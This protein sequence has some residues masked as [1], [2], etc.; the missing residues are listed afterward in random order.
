MIMLVRRMILIA[1]LGWVAQWST[2]ALAQTN[3]AIRIVELSGTV[4]ILGHGAADW[5]PAAT[6]AQLHPFDRV[7]TGTNG[8]LGL[9]WSD[10][11]VLRFGALTEL[12]ILPADTAETDRGLHLIRGLLSFFHRD[13]PGRIRVI[14]SGALAGI[15]GTEFVMD[16]VPKNGVQQTTLSVIDGQVRFSN[17]A[18]ALILTN[19]EQA[20]AEPGKAPVRTPGFIAKN[21]LQWCFYYPGVLDPNDL[22]LTPDESTRLAESI[23]AYRAGDL[24]AA[25]AKYSGPP[26]SDAERVYHAALLLSVGHVELA[27]ADL[28]ALKETGVGKKNRRLAVALRTLIAAVKHEP[29]S[30]LL[31]PELATELLAAS[32]YEQSQDGPKALE[33]ALEL[34]RHAVAIS[35]DFGFG[36]ERVAELEFS[37]GRIDRASAALDQALRLSPRNAQALALKGFLLAAKNRTREAIAWFDRALGVDSTLGN[38]WLGRGLCRIRLG[39]SAG[40]REDLLIAAAME[41]QR[42]SLRSYLGKAYGDAGEIHRAIHELNLAKQMDTN[43]PTAWLYS[44]LLNEQKNHINEAINDLE[45]SQELNDN[46]SVYRS[47]LLLD[48]DRAV[49]SANLARIYQEAGMDLVSLQEA[50]RAVTEDYANYSAHLFLAN[51]YNSLSDPNEINLRYQTSTYDEYL[52]G[53]LL[54]P[55]SAGVFSPSISQQEYSRLFERDGFGVISETTYLSRGAWSESGAQFGTSGNFSYDLEGLYDADNGQR[56]NNDIEERQLSLTLKQQLTPQDSLFGTVINYNADGGDLFQRYYQNNAD[57]GLRTHEQQQPLAEAGYHHQWSPGLDTLLLVGR[58]QDTYDVRDT[59]A[60]GTILF[61]NSPSTI[62]AFEDGTLLQNYQSETVIY[63]A[64]LQQLWKTEPNQLIVG[65]RFQYGNFRTSNLLSQPQGGLFSIF[66]NP[67][68][69]DAANQYVKSH[70]ERTSAYAY[71]LWQALDSLQLEGG[72]SYDGITF[73]EDFRSDPLAG[74]QQSENQV[75]PK[76]GFIWTPLEKTVVRGA[77]TRSLSGASVEQ[78]FQI[79]PTE[80]AGFNQLFRSIIPESIAGENSGAHFET[81][82]IDVEQKFGTGTYLSASGEMLRSRVDRQAG[83]FIDD[84]NVSSYPFTATTP[85]QLNYQERTLQLRADQLLGRYFVLGAGYRLSDS[86]LHDDFNAELSGLGFDSRTKAQLQQFDAEA[87]VN[88]PIGFFGGAQGLW[89]G[90][91]NSGYTPALPDEYF[92]QVNLFAGYRSPRRH[93][94][95]TVGLLN[96]T[97][98]DYDLNPLTPYNDLPRS[99]TLSVQ[100]KLDF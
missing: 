44:A 10:Q 13:R 11:S 30:S 34:A 64:E 48:E 81:W 56:A 83:V 47:G 1:S 71:D 17:S 36:W 98:R 53:N 14:T 42:A 3:E 96:L 6:G 78:S 16:V 23:A 2:P 80:V 50:S 40:G 32:Y 66:F 100:L 58:L 45:K 84:F 54:A 86:S 15:E 43:D 26:K 79:E 68:T 73:P 22:L 62:N 57:T 89:A 12:E 75:S 31:K 59:N 21:L 19:G 8:S 60:P 72:L 95:I 37:F 39:D 93:L 24:L 55:A 5:F 65:G 74:G 91:S 38:A 85:E 94:E 52:V 27:E 51:S 82:D 9:L 25:L 97:G 76:A 92:W 46:R 67:S 35:P 88:L 61:G 33:N 99:R 70:L 29:R 87:L 69:P 28:S 63:S 18:A 90:Q 7:R 20:V 41:P 77:Y 4:E 49:R